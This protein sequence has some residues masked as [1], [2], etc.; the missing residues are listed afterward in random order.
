MIV[1]LGMAAVT[2]FTR[3]AG[4]AAAGRALPPL[5]QQWLKFVPVAVLA[6]LIAPAALTALAPGGQLQMGA[7]SL[8]LIAGLVIAWRTRNVF[9]TVAAGMATFWVLQLMGM[10]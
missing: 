1:F 8:A 3:Y 10:Q 5:V 4:I 9:W 6:A 2:F 7:S